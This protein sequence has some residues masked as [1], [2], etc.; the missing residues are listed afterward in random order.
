MEDERLLVAPEAQRVVLDIE[1][2]VE[3]LRK[4][5]REEAKFTDACVLWQAMQS[6]SRMDRAGTA[7]ASKHRRCS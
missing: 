7:R 1:T 6:S 5:L 3:L 2:L 4:H